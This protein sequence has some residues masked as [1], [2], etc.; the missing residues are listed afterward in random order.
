[1]G[2]GMSYKAS[3]LGIKPTKYNKAFSKANEGNTINFGNA[4]SVLEAILNLANL[5]SIPTPPI[6]P[7]VAL[8]GNQRGGVSARRLAG[9]VISR[10][11]EAGAPIGPRPDGSISQREMLEVIRAEEYMGEITRNLRVSTGALPGQSVVI[12]GANGGGPLV[13]YGSTTVP[14]F[15]SSAVC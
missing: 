3:D 1:M 9:N 2:C 12:S 10:F 6:P 7:P 15:G 13:G 14:V 11:E 8:L 5:D 4:I